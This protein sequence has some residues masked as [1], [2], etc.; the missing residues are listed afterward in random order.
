MKI[1]VLN[2]S[3]RP[4]GNTRKLIGAFTEGAESQGHEVTVVDVCKKNIHGC[5]GC[6]HCHMKEKEV[7]VQKDD[8]HEIYA[9][10]KETN[11]IVFASPV[12][13][14]DLSA[15]LRCV[16]DRF[17][18]VGYPGELKKLSKV[19]MILSSGSPNV[20]DG[21]LYAYR[22][23]FIEYMGLEDKGILTVPGSANETALA[24]ARALGQSL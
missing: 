5:L 24:K 14:H 1:L 8:M 20:Y 16:I 17:Y 21:I 6:E 10:L 23:N 19:A 22:Q 15:Q 2:G 4:A 7:C 13:Y 11:M 18:A 12:Y 3:P 9:L